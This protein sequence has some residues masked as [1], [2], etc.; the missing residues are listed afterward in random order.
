LERGLTAPAQS[1]TG[2]D[3]WSLLSIE[4][5]RDPVFKSS[6]AVTGVLRPVKFGKRPF[7]IGATPK[8]AAIPSIANEPFQDQDEEP[9]DKWRRRVPKTMLKES[10]H[11]AVR[12]KLDASTGEF[13][14]ISTNGSEVTTGERPH[15]GRGCLGK[16]PIQTFLDAI[17][18]ARK[19]AIAA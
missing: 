12:K 1:S 17:P 11:I 16:T 3:T 9:V 13:W 14:T 6:A 2:Q 7:R 8:I 5:A 4:E 10:Y 18:I 19:K 15:Q